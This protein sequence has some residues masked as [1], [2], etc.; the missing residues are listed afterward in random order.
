[1]SAF[2]LQPRAGDIEVGSP[3][4]VQRA[5]LDG[6]APVPHASTRVRLALPGEVA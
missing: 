5:T 1:M 6:D 2:D 3:A 4:A